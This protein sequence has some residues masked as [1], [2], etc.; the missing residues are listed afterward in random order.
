MNYYAQAIS[1]ITDSN[2][3]FRKLVLEIAK[4]HPKIIVDAVL[5]HGWQAEA[6]LLIQAGQK[7]DAIRL[8]RNLT[9]LSLKEAKDAVEAL[10]A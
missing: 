2:T 6:R 5:K 10:V 7:I 4:S 9:G 8:C 1:I 3:D